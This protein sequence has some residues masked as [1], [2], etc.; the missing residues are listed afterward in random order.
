[1]LVFVLDKNGHPLMP[2][3]NGA[4]VRVLLKQ[5]RA[6]V[7]LKCPFT[8]KLLYESTTFV[9]PLTLGVDT[10]SKYVGSAVVNDVTSEIVYESQVELRD[11]IK[12]KMDR[13][14]QFRKGRRG[15]L[16]YRPK[17]FNN[18]KSSKRKERYTPTLISKF[19]GHIREIKIAVSILPIKDIVLE[20][21]EFD[22]HLLQDPTLAYHKWGYQKGEL[23]QQENFKQTARARDD[24]KCQ[25]CGKK[26]CRLEVHHLLPRSR[27]GSDKLANL[28]TLCSDCHHLA[29][30]SEEQLLEFQKKFGKKAKGTLRYATQMNVLRCMLQR[31]Y[32]DA[33]VTYGFITKEMR[34]VFGLEKSHMVDACCIASRGTLFRNDNPNKYKKKCVP[35]GDYARTGVKGGRFVVLSKGKI[36]G[37]RRYDKVLYNNKEY[38]VVGR[39]S[40]GKIYLID[41]DNNRVQVE[42]TKRSTGEKYTSKAEIK[43]SLVKKVTS[44]K[45][46]VCVKE[47]GFNGNSCKY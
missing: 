31:E 5:K 20:V 16:R 37:F 40:I 9:Q 35:K 10:G 45:S 1:M 3:H 6:K 38:F 41:I 32:P 33:E 21:G 24:Y 17:R 47:H 44:A 7:V 46:C 43:V 12:Q 15:K 14:R 36:A 29:H 22:P 30:S 28:I 26:G 18:I 13:R 11:D 4:K 19:Q 23:Y 25:C 27:G 2:T 8:I 34:R 42:R 39:M